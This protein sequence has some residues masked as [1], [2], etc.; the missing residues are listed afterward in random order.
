MDVYEKLPPE[1]VIIHGSIPRRRR[2]GRAARKQVSGDRLRDV[3]MKWSLPN[4]GE[5]SSYE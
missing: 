3:Q 4:E 5:V 1:V 2:A